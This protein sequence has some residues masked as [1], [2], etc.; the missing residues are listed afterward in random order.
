[1]RKILVIFII[2][3]FITIC[4]IFPSTG[5][6]IFDED[7]TPPVTTHEF[8]GTMGYEDWFVSDVTILL[9]A[10][11]D[12]S[13]V[14][15]TYYRL[16]N[17]EWEVYAVPINIWDEGYHVI[18]YY[19]V[20]NAGNEED[21]KG[22]F[23]FKKDATPPT[24]ELTVEEIGSNTWLLIADVF[25]ET[26][27]VNWVEFYVDEELIGTI[28]E[29]PYECEWSGIGS[30][31]IAQAIVC[32]NAGNYGIIH[33]PPQIHPTRVLGIICNL[34]FTDEDI[35]FFAMIVISNTFHPCILRQLTFQNDYSGYI[36]ERFIFAV[37]EYGPV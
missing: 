30:G 36:G 6:M 24:I 5:K 34:E 12:I 8:Y 37:F 9:T 32:D 4:S 15:V 23:D 1:M 22:P 7:I 18:E 19:S 35:S 3:I 13:G 33:S 31:H 16:N 14:N 17:G 26:S 27:G 29:E 25:D 21:V 10:T 2:L 28:T 20:D 11:D